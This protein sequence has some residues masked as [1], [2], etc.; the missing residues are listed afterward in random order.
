MIMMYDNDRT[1]LQG[2]FSGRL[3]YLGSRSRI[4]I[5]YN[6][7]RVNFQARWVRRET[8]LILSY[9][10]IENLLL[11]T[12][13]WGISK[14]RTFARDQFKNWCGAEKKD[15]AVKLHGK[16]STYH[17]FFQDSEAANLTTPPLILFKSDI[18]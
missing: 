2:F 10:I 13:C 6:A 1:K 9:I 15:K 17:Y 14:W 12:P 3:D 4:T 5:Q 7:Q 16:T 8:L 18:L 11:P